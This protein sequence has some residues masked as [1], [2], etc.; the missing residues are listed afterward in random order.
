MAETLNKLRRVGEKQQQKF[1]TI[2]LL[3]VVYCFIGTWNI[4]KLQKGR[5]NH[6]D[7]EIDSNSDGEYEAT[8][9]NIVDFILKIRPIVTEEADWCFCFAFI[10]KLNSCLPNRDDMLSRLIWV[11]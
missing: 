5:N 3:A 4:T 2:K 1:N 8:D 9:F 6:V 7:I 11:L 10:L